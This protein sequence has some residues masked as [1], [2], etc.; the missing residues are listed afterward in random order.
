MGVRFA[1]HARSVK[2]LQGVSIKLHDFNAIQ[3]CKVFLWLKE[4]PSWG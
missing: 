1:R 4:M 2:A 3:M